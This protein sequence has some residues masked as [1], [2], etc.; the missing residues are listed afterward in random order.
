MYGIGSVRP[1][2]LASPHVLLL[3]PPLFWAGNAVAARAYAA[4]IP[5][6]ALSFWRWTLALALLLPAGLPRVAAAWP[7]VRA[8]WKLFAVEG[9]LS[10]AAYNTL[11]YMALQ[12]TTAINATLV[13]ASLPIIVVLLSWVW[14]GQRVSLR[15]AAGVAL[16]LSGVLAVVARGRPEVLLGLEFTSGDVLMIVAT[17]GW[18]VYS[19][20]LR[21]NP[22]GLDPVAFL[23]V[24]IAVGVALI[25]P[26]YLWEAHGG[27]R[28]SLDVGALAAIAY[29]AVFASLAAFLL[30]NRGVAA[31]GATVAGLYIYLI[32][33]FTALMAIPL[34]GERF[35]WFHAVG[36]AMIFTGIGL[37]TRNSFAVG[38]QKR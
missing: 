9:A 30:W 7:L 36:T 23:T 8:H 11:L 27:A 31:V 21:R 16:S 15:Q 32:P 3:L 37:A 1:F 5:P 26:L 12:S 10:V 22:P 35:Q 19:L 18:A 4:E 14:L 33:A 25:L 6:H 17:T 34:L 29:T 38:R 13:S 24:Q 2:A 20:L 28:M